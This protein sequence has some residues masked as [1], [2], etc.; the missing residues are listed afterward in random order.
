MISDGSSNSSSVAMT[1]SR[2]TNSGIKPYLTRSSG[3]TV[4]S[5]SAKS[6][7]L[8]ISLTLA[9]NP[10]PDLSVLFCI[11]LS[12]PENAPPTINSIPDVST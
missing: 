3:P 9:E 10:I 7:F 11:I 5:V 6:T 1:G 2:P 12:R 4:P 8:L